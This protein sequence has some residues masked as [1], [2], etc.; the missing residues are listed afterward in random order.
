LHRGQYAG[1]VPSHHQPGTSA[2]G[3]NVTPLGHL[4]STGFFARQL[5]KEAVDLA[6]TLVVLIATG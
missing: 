1:S 5:K 6:Y 2:G 3:A 4:T